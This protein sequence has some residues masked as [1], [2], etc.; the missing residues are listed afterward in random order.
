MAIRYRNYDYFTITLSYTQR[1]VRRTH[2]VA[3]RWQ[4]F[5]ASL[6]SSRRARVAYWLFKK[7]YF[8]L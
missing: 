1:S 4:H 6:K 8:E 7:G 5:W 2:Q 3:V